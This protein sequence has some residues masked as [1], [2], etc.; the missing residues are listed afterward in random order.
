M[1]L[2]IQLPASL[3][4]NQKTTTTKLA[5]RSYSLVGDRGD[6]PL[7]SRSFQNLGNTLWLFMHS[8][9]DALVYGTPSIFQTVSL[10]CLETNPHAD[11]P[12]FSFARFEP[13]IFPGRR[14]DCYN[15]P[16]WNGH[17]VLQVC[18]RLSAIWAFMKLILYHLWGLWISCPLALSLVSRHK[19]VHFYSSSFYAA[20]GWS[21]SDHKV[22]LVSS[23]SQTG[24]KCQCA[25]KSGHSC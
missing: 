13:F 3:I 25:S 5:R 2:I 14:C 23:F 6:P 1:T 18:H 17:I 11:T 21:V 8:S 4:I 12:F 16:Q 7:R 24:A 20:S 19:S 9:F 22:R 10:S 15:W